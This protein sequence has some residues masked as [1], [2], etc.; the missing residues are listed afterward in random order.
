M[1]RLY[2]A[3]VAQAGPALP[4]IPQITLRIDDEGSAVLLAAEQVKPLSFDQP[5]P[6]ITAVGDAPRQ[7]D[8]VVAA[9]LG[10]VNIRMGHKGSAIALVAEAPDRAG[11]RRLELRQSRCGAGID[12]I[13]DRVETLDGKTGVPVDD[14]PLG[15]RGMGRQRQKDLGNRRCP[16][17]DNGNSGAKPFSERV[18][19]SFLRTDRET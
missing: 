2:E 3:V 7:I 6:G 18:A 15:R 9:E 12:E 11:L 19:F 4:G 5:E 14:D 1:H 17:R 10:P 13:G 16:Y 8:R